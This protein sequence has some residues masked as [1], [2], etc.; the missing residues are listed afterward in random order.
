[1]ISY[2]YNKMEINRSKLQ[3]GKLRTEAGKKLHRDMNASIAGLGCS[4]P[5]LISRY[6]VPAVVAY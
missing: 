2:L 4:L 6:A 5:K 3:Q 1:M